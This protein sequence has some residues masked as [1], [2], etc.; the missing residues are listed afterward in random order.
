MPKCPHCGSTAQVREVD[1]EY[2]TSWAA[3]NQFNVITHY[4]CGCGTKFCRTL[5]CVSVS[6]VI[7][8]ER[9]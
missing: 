1:K 5:V 4:Q 3:P 2:V 8:E 7:T 9:P 6:E